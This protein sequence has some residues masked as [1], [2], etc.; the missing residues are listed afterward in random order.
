MNSERRWLNFYDA[1]KEVRKK[2]G[3][4]VGKAQTML[5]EV[6]AK[7][8][9][10]TQREPYNPATGQGQAPPERVKP[11]QWKQ[12]DIDLLTDA[13]GCNYFVDLDEEDF[14][15]WLGSL[16]EPKI[17]KRTAPME[18]LARKTIAKL[19]LPA[20]MSNTEVHQ[21]IGKELKGRRV[22]SPSVIKRL[23]ANKSTN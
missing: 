16:A 4:S 21:A 10:R 13:D 9:I 20:D 1:A 12:D 17:K 7:G 3:V 19:G 8:D 23:R 6:C 14:E 22:P 15:Y 18:E 5:R 11:S 2:L